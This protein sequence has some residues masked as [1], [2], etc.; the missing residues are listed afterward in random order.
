MII[1]FM[2]LLFNIAL[3]SVVRKVKKDNIGLRIR[4]KNVLIKTFADECRSNS[5]E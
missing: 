4:E 1:I 2:N 5:I 3:E